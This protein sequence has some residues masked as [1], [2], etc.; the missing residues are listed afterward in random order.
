MPLLCKHDKHRHDTNTN[1]NKYRQHT[2]S[3]RQSKS[4]R[5]HRKSNRKSK[6]SKSSSTTTAT[7]AYSEET[8]PAPV[9]RFSG[10]NN[11]RKKSSRASSTPAKEDSPGFSRRGYKPRVQSSSV[12]QGAVAS[13]SL[14]K[15]KLNRYVRVDNLFITWFLVILIL[16]AILYPFTKPSI[17]RDNSWTKIVFSYWTLLFRYPC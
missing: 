17:I 14:Y 10:N 12:D 5:G 7:T 2:S 1:V 6:S 3:Q 4:G 8:T 16:V 9:K 13:T 15:F 11:N